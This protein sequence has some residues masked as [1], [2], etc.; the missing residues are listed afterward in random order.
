MKAKKKYT[1]GGKMT[2]EAMMKYMMGGKMPKA[3]NGIK[4]DEVV[5]KDKKGAGVK[6]AS[7]VGRGKTGEEYTAKRQELVAAEL[8]KLQKGKAPGYKPTDRERSDAMDRVRQQLTKEG[9]QERGV[10]RKDT[11]TRLS[12]ED[13]AYA[14][15]R[16][17]R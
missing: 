17:K 13:E 8:A 14:K 3:Q 2:K 1:S 7:V 11:K 16:M 5:V 9:Y 4:L 6:E 10:I 15:D 12:P